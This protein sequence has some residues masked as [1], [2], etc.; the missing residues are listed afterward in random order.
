MFRQ[1]RQGRCGTASESLLQR[2]FAQPEL[3]AC[4]SPAPSILDWEVCPFN[5]NHIHERRWKVAIEVT[6]LSST[7]AREDVGC[8]LS[9]VS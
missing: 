3:Q 7:L 1:P 5:I 6:Y 2:I 4:L 8:L 9:L